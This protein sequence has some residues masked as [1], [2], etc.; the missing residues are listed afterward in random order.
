MVT[1]LK[2][3]GSGGILPPK[4]AGKDARTTFSSFVVFAEHGDSSENRRER[5]HLA[6]ERSRQGCLH[7]NFHRSWCSQNMGTYLNPS[8]TA[9]S[10]Y[11]ETA[12]ITQDMFLANIRDSILQFR[13]TI[14]QI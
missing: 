5:R 12:H 3:E 7:H 9:W 6:A 11:A 13:S 14:H 10:K 4:D 2:I 8:Q 1:P